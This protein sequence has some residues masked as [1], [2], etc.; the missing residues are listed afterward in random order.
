MQKVALCLQS[1]TMRFELPKLDIALQHN[2][3][4]VAVAK[5]CGPTSCTTFIVLFELPES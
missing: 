5:V 4:N 1:T 2:T 3:L